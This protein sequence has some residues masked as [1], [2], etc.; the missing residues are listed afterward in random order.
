[1]PLSLLSIL[2][3]FSAA[4]LV[5]A[6]GAAMTQ[7]AEKVALGKRLFEDTRLSEPEGQACASCHQRQHGFADPGKITSPGANQQLHGNR[8]A[9][10]I[11]YIKFNPELFYNAEEQLWMGGFFYDGRAKTLQQQASGPF[12]NPLEMANKRPAD[13]LAKVKQGNY[14]A[15]FEQVY[16]TDIW[17]DSDH[18][19]AA[20]TEAISAY[21]AGPEFARFDSKF[22]YYLQG[23]VTL[24]PLE[25][26]GLALFEAKDKGNCAAC[27]PSQPAA[28]GQPVLFTDYS[29][30]N[31]GLPANPAL[32]FYHL[33]KQ[34][35]SDGLNYRDP[36]LAAN[37]HIDNPQAERGKFKVPS[38]RNVALSAPY[39]HHGVINSLKETVEFYNQRDAS[40]KRWGAAEVSSTVNA[41][42][43]GDLKLSEQEVDA[44]V[45][46]LKTLS[47][48]YA[49]GQPEG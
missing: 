49:L 30:D 9:P 38:L 18:A 27:H 44:I 23:K 28:E 15:L 48:G 39:F 47:D 37:P 46:F 14:K 3:F 21:Q 19:F 31:L 25:Q 10:A 13:V 16:G 4:A 41:E 1:M 24:S 12:L 33:P 22:D 45:A 29:Y 7:N 40:P 8:N 17:S 36:G 26:Q 20:I 5:E 32:A 34:H 42:E 11:A 6:D 43:L 35:N 2:L